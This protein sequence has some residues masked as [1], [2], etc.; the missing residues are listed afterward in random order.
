MLHIA[1]SDGIVAQRLAA[2][3]AQCRL[4]EPEVEIRLFEVPLS[5]QTKGLRND[6]YDAG[7]SR[8][9]EDGDSLRFRS[10]LAR[11]TDC[12]STCASSAAQLRERLPLDEVLKYPLALCHPESCEGHYKQIER[13]LRTVDT[14]TDHRQYVSSYDVMLALV[15]AGYGLRPGM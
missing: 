11:P 13:L 5:Q 1:L 8:S 2:L 14:Q 3:L 12:R 6:L 15:A 4:E 10:R 9:D 7:F